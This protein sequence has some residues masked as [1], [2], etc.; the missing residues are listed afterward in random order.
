MKVS[1][2][3]AVFNG[4]N[5]IED[6]I[7]SVLGQSY[8]NVEYIII[9]GASTDGTLDII[10]KYNGQIGKVISEPD[11]GIYDALNKGIKLATGDIIGFLHSDDIYAHEKVLENVV[12][13]FRKK[14]VD[15][16]YGDLEYVKREDINKIVRYWK[17][18]PYKNRNFKYG[19]MLP[20]PTF[21]VKREIYNQYGLFNT[22]FKIAADYEI[23]LRFLEKYKISTYYIP[24][25][26]IK[27]RVGGVSNKSLK[28]IFIKTFEDHK[29]WKINNLNKRYYTILLKNLSKIPQFF[30]KHRKGDMIL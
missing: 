9:D 27:M 5:V 17:S 13:V 6:C 4:V 15:S 11:K 7:N 3:T 23:I 29:A 10:R 26:F 18:S 24:D 2:I 1:I 28:N 25:V 22:C 12:N 30:K 14:N 16:C 21:F 20:H 19:W 8:K